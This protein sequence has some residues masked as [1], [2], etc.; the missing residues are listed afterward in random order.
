MNLID[1][2]TILAFHK[3]RIENYGAGTPVA[4]GWKTVSSQRR[5]FEILTEIGNLNNHSVLDVGC[6]H[7][8]MQAYLAE[9]YARHHYTGIEQMLSFLEVTVKRFGNWPNTTFYGGDFSTLALPRS[10]YVLASGA[11]GYRS[12]EP[13]FVPEMI[14][15]LFDACRLGFG[16]NMLRR[17]AHPEGILAAYDPDGILAH[18]RSLTPHL[19]LREGCLDDD[20]TI[21]MYRDSSSIKSLKDPNLAV[22]ELEVTD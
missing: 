10:D 4:L 14:T 8:D 17:V 5:R 3:T 7:G 2:A 9:Q 16:F 22:T 18:C 19:I 20:F 13:G 12:S 6:G 1:R 11:L 15:R 21:F